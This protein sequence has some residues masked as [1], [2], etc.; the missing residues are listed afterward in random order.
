MSDSGFFPQE[1]DHLRKLAILYRDAKALILYSEEIDPDSRSNLQ[2]IKELRD[3]FDHLMRVVSFHLA[4][5]EVAATAYDEYCHKNVQ[6]AIGHVYRAAFDALDGTVLS[7]RER[8]S[9]AL[10]GYHTDVIKTVIPE[11][12][13]I[14]IELNR[15]TDA[16]AD[17]RGRKDVGRDVGATLDKY[18]EDIEKLKTFHDRLLH[19]GNELDVQQQAY[20][21][22]KRGSWWRQVIGAILAAVVGGLIVLAAQQVSWSEILAPPQSRLPLEQNS[23]ED[24]HE[25]GAR[26]N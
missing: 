20:D 24:A 18:V 21:H 3:A 2:T 12:W 15:L 7:L 14:K 1:A 11:Y 5:D 19:A 17:H 16:V 23:P 8:I 6:K 13:D 25:S 9:A 22:E 10:G 26:R 4:P